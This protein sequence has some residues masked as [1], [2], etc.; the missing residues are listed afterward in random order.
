MWPPGW[1]GFLERN[2]CVVTELGQLVV[3]VL[4]DAIV[5]VSSAAVDTESE[6]GTIL[7]MKVHRESP[8]WLE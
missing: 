8:K 5:D 2:L 6:V 7:G 1:L 3:A 4:A